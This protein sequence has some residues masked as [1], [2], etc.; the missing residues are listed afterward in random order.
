[1]SSRKIA[2]SPS[3]TML[4]AAPLIGVPD[5]LPFAVPETSSASAS[6]KVPSTSPST[7]CRPASSGSVTAFSTTAVAPLVPPVTVFPA[8]A[9]VSPMPSV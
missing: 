4:A 8:T 9:E 5:A 3:S 1:M 7:Y 6:S 2:N